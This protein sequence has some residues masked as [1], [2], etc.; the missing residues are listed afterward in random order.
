MADK[1]L[2]FI[3]GLHR[4]GTTLLYEM[5]GASGLF[6]IV[7]A[8]DVIYYDS[9]ATGLLTRD[10]ASSE[11]TARLHS[12]GLTNRVV[13]VVNINPQ[14]PEEYG[15]ILDNLRGGHSITPASFPVFEQVVDTLHRIKG[16]DK[17]LLLKNPYDFGQGAVIKRLM[18]DA[19]LVYIHR[20]PLHVLSSF[21]R[22]IELAVKEPSPYLAMLSR[23]Y[24]AMIESDFPMRVARAA[25]QSAERLAAVGVI[26]QTARLARGYLH[27]LSKLADHDRIEIR[28]EDLCANPNQTMASIFHHVGQSPPATDFAEMI[29]K[30]QSRVAPQIA[31]QRALILREFGSYASAVGYDIESLFDTD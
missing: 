8:T 22:L 12:H 5:L 14:T 20:N 3:L 15:F 28:Y 23:R 16:D 1:P 4:S 7:T 27:S 25:F 11:L 21:H 30:H 19:K 9:L 17:P 18:P 13:D 6:H 29:G 26:K 10:Q 31:R 24:A 2:V